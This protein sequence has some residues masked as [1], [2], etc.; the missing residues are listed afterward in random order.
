M[1]AIVSWSVLGVELPPVWSGARLA[2]PQLRCIKSGQLRQAGWI[3]CTLKNLEH[4]LNGAHHYYLIYIKRGKT[5]GDTF[6]LL[7]FAEG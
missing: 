4:C 3:E 6:D 7:D 2:L 5:A 1:Q